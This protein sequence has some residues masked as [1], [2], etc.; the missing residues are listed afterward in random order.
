MESNVKKTGKHMYLKY[1]YFTLNDIVPVAEKIFADLGI[2]PLFDF[3]L[4]SDGNMGIA[5]M[6]IRDVTDESNN[7][8][9]QLPMPGLGQLEK[10]PPIQ[11]LGANITYIRRYLY[12]AALDITEVDI[13]D[14]GL[15][16]TPQEAPKETPKPPAT[17]EKRKEI[18]KEL[19]NTNGAAT[20][21]QKKRL[22]KALTKLI[23]TKPETQDVVTKILTQ[24]DG[25]KKI[26]KQE[27]EELMIQISELLE[28]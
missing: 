26:T 13:T 19:T 7:L 3:A 8:V 12:M 2:I 24:T 27:C 23:E 5:T 9:I 4:P 16:E 22:E 17:P 28:G 20:D 11:E 18:K 6:T 15:I 10:L 25:L 21:M 14:E 1:K